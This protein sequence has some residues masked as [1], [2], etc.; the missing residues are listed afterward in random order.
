MDNKQQMIGVSR[1][2]IAVL[3]LAGVSLCLPGCDKDTKRK[4]AAAPVENKMSAAQ[5]AP[6]PPMPHGGMGDMY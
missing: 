3:I 5:E 4:A 6:M 2:T 1:G